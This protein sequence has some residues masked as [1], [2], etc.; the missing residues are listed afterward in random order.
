VGLSALRADPATVASFLDAAERLRDS[1]L[2]RRAAAIADQ[3][4]R[5]GLSS[6]ATAPLVKVV[7]R[8][9]RRSV[10]VSLVSASGVPTGRQLRRPVWGILRERRDGE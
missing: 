9:V 7:L 5:R 3:H 2:S 6:P 1:A 4:R 8:D 10:R